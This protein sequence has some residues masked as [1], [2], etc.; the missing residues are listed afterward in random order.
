MSQPPVHRKEYEIVDYPKLDHV[1]S[2]IVRI[3]S[4]NTHAHRAYELGLVLEGSAQ[5][6]LGSKSFSIH[7]GSLFFFNANESHEIIAED[8]EGAIIAYLQVAGSFCSDY[9][10]CFRNLEVLEN[11]LSGILTPEQNLTLTG[12][13]IQALSDYMAEFSQL[14]ALRCI[15]SI[16]ALYSKL[17]EVVP[18]RQL[19]DA[20]Y[21][22]RNRKMARLI[23][24]TSYIEQN[25]AEK[26]SLEELA[27]Q[28]GVTPTYLSHFIRDN[29]P[30]TFQSY[31]TS[32]RFQRALK[33]LQSTSMNLTDASVVCGFSDVKYLSKLLEK[34][35]GVPAQEACRQLRQQTGSLQ[36]PESQSFLSDNA[37]VKLLQEFWQD[38]NKKG[39]SL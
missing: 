35:F 13:M 23:R 12:L 1:R 11:D 37:C 15:S 8:K 34:E 6:R 5:V 10:T 26:L 7:K 32:I 36:K 2:S 19:S 39:L 4:R 33:L 3:V 27:R 18:Y 17:L 29:L 31:V 14:Y 9:L 20:A 22:A 24:I 30:M 38:L 25:A 21:M 16:C 28:E